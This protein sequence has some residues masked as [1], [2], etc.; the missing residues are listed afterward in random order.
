MTKDSI[1]DF[2]SFGSAT[3]MASSAPASRQKA[4]SKVGRLYTTE[5]LTQSLTKEFTSSGTRSGPGRPCPPGPL[6]EVNRLV[7]G[8]LVLDVGRSR[9][10][11]LEAALANGVGAAPV[12]QVAALR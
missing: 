8:E 1:Q 5:A 2:D 4:C 12:D 9:R 10:L 11:R 6:V 7:P 3:L